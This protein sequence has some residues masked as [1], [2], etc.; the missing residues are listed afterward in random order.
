MATEVADFCSDFD[1]A[2]AFA[3]GVNFGFALE[4]DFSLAFGVGLSTESFANILSIC[5]LN[6]FS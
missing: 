2:S 6:V 1:I 5:C 4:V 3:F